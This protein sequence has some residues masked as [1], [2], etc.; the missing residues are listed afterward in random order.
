MSKLVWDAVGEHFYETGVDHGVLYPQSSGAYPMGYA[1][2]G[3]TS[4]S[5]SPEGADETEIYADNIKYLSLR[6]IEKF[7][8]TINA[9]TYPEEFAQCDG[10]ASIATGVTI[11]QQ[12]R[13]PFGFTYRTVIGNDTDGEDHGYKIHIIYGATAAPSSRDYQT[14][15]D[16][17][18]AIEFSWEINT[19][20]V[21]VS[22]KKPTAYVEI[23]STAFTQETVSKLH[24]LEDVLYGFDAPAFD[25]TQTYAVG[26]RCTHESKIY[27]C[28]T[29]ITTAAAWDATKWTE[30]TGGNNPRLPLP[31]EIVTL[32]S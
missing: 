15:N 28:T 10:S 24:D 27:K 18:E 13:V 8:A 25:A 9:Y 11:R 29:A 12:K 32:M 23:D 7:N 19:T 4:V 2:N 1:W 14:I 26:D 22:G 3:L 21:N 5:E 17:P 20:P 6:S 31:D 30:L 16:S